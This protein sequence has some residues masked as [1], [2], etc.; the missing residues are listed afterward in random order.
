M[1]KMIK[2]AFGLAVSALLF[3]QPAQAAMSCWG[4]QEAAAAKI[5][6][7]QSRLMVAAMRCR[8]M[9]VDVLAQYNQ[10]VRDNRATIQQANGVLK[11]QFASGYG[12][13]GDTFYDRFTTALANEYG[14]EPTSGEICEEVALEASE[15]A[16]AQGDLRRLLELA[17]RLGPTPE[18]PG[19]ECPISFSSR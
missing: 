14:A 11:A 18:L 9:G 3:V 15:A 10:F 5:R 1:T 17:D 12:A 13:D 8:A 4:P 2:G 19:G 6:D 7:L 16:A